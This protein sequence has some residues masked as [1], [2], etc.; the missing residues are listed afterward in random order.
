LTIIKLEDSKA[1]KLKIENR[2]YVL[3]IIMCLWVRDSIEVWDSL[4]ATEWQNMNM[5]QK[6]FAA[7]LE[8]PQRVN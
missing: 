4:P 8:D 6:F 3:I 1:E 5:R 7:T 2:F